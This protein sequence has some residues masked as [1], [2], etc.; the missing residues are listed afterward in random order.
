MRAISQLVSVHQKRIMEQTGILG[1]WPGHLNF[2]KVI[3]RGCNLK[4]KIKFQG[5]LHILID[6]LKCDQVHARL[7]QSKQ[8][9]IYRIL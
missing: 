8:Y 5:R 2:T 6:C 7:P 9:R 4:T 3:F 1:C